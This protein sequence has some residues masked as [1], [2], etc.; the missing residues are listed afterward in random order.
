MSSD[1]IT[2]A[3]EGLAGWSYD[4]DALV[5]KFTF[6]DFAAAIDF[7]AAARPQIDELNHHPEWTNV[8]N[9]V[10]VRLNSHDVGGVTDR[11]FQLARLLDEC[12]E[13]GT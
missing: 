3:L 13:R 2:G 1:E 9:R 5:K 7:M 11:D 10:D 8:Y 12:A 4:G 6:D